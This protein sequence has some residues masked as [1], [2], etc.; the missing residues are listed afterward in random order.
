MND[1]AYAI[2][3]AEYYQQSK[4]MGKKGIKNQLYRRG[5]DSDIIRAILSRNLQGD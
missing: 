5:I 1:E 2:K 4:G 3:M